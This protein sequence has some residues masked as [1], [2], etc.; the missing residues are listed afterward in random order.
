MAENDFNQ[1]QLLQQNL[2]NILLQRQQFQ[3]QLAEIDSALAELETSPTA[4]KIVGSIMISA[5]RESLQKELREKKEI[6]DL[7]LKNFAKQEKLLKEKTE[8]T[9]KKV[10]EEIRKKK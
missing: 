10:L 8:E 4:Y 3:K 1:L 9:Q 2:Q 6:L 5:P 7:R